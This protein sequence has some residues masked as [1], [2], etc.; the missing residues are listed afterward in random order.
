MALLRQAWLG[1]LFL[2]VPVIF[3]SSDRILVLSPAGEPIEIV[4]PSDLSTETS[5]QF[6]S[7]VVKVLQSTD[8]LFYYLLGRIGGQ[9]VTVVDADSLEVSK[10]IPLPTGPFDGVVTPDGKYLLVAAAE[11]SVI[12]LETNELETTVDVGNNARRVLVDSSSSMAF[13]I[14]GPAYERRITA[15]SL[16]TMGA[17]GVT[18]SE[19]RLSDMTFADGGV[20]LVVTTL[21]D[22]IVYSTETLEEINRFDLNDTLRDPVLDLVSGTD[23]VLV[24]GQNLTSQ[25]T[26]LLVDFKTGESQLVGLSGANIFETIH[27]FDSTRA[28]GILHTTDD[29]VQLDLTAVGRVTVESLGLQIQ[30]ID[31]GFSPDRSDL[32]VVEGGTPSILKID[33]A[34]NEVVGSSELTVT[35]TGE[36]VL[37]VPSD[38]PPADIGVLSGNGQIILAGLPLTNPLTARVLDAL[39][40]PVPNVAV[41]FEDFAGAGV[42]FQSS[43]STQ[44][45]AFGDAT[46]SV[47]APPHD[48][49]Q[50]AGIRTIS[51]SAVAPNV[52]PAFFSIDVA[53]TVGLLKVS[54]DHQIVSVFSDFPKPIV[55]LATDENGDL[56]PP[57]TE[58]TVATDQATCQGSRMVDQSGFI[59]ATC[60]SFGIPSQAG[61][62]VEGSVTFRREDLGP[63]LGIARFEFTTALAAEYLQIDR[64]SGDEQTGP[65]GQPLFVPLV[66]KIA[67]TG[68]NNVAAEVTQESG[69]PVSFSPVSFFGPPFGL[70]S[71][72]AVAGPVEG[73]ATVKVEVPAPGFPSVTFMVNMTPIDAT[74]ITKF[75]DGQTGSLFTTLPLPLIVTVLG[76][77]GQPILFPDVTWEVVSGLA[78]IETLRTSTGSRATV[79]FG[80][81]PGEILIRASIGALSAIFSTMIEPPEPDQL[82]ILSG[83]GQSLEAGVPS[84][85]L[86]V[87]FREE[88]RLAAG[89]VVTVTGP[90]SL[91]FRRAGGEEPANPLVVSADI[92]GVAQV[93]VELID[94]SSLASANQPSGQTTSSFDVLVSSGS[95]AETIS[96]GVIGRTP[97]FSASSITNAA[98]FQAVGLVPGGLV[99][100]FGNGFMQGITQVVEPGGVT[101]FAG[102]TV[103]IDGEKAPLLTLAPGALEQVNVQVPFEL[104]P[105]QLV[106][107]M[108]DNNGTMTTV[109]NVAVFP[110]QPGIFALPIGDD[111]TGGAVLHADDFS[112]VTIAN[113]AEIG[114]VL[115]VYYTG[116]GGLVDPGVPTG[117]LG[118][119]DPPAVITAQ[120]IL[121]V[122]GVEAELLFTGYAP[123][124]LGLYQTNFIVPEGIGCGTVSLALELSAITGPNSAL[125]IN[126]P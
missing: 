126:C 100:I 81:L 105:G 116:G 119:V 13:V 40:Q 117:V 74:Q 91:L 68:I 61:V 104:T 123:S 121:R 109:D 5:L 10:V 79:S 125:P 95:V 21:T 78:T 28:Y 98:T 77:G 115:A 62:A 59:T 120:S 89:A 93:V 113:P 2:V 67:S 111:Q 26:T 32:F 51:I 57:G 71:I 72:S 23:K 6:T 41:L 97:E 107:V 63:E 69:P 65:V 101:S 112:F 70:E 3:A 49:Q 55:V 27:V 122:D 80:G 60:V 56:L 16:T 42:Q 24:Q 73:A 4:R 35:P 53:Q 75:N 14:G 22:V 20:L 39:G 36:A 108:I 84:E 50:E 92:Q 102:T 82:T 83:Q 106:S 12:D 31:I 33:T 48:A 58:V 52:P 96:F 88:G 37:F 90:P 94:I 25:N 85:P 103:W 87:V 66:F 47:V 76:A 19:V 17:V 8:G 1:L 38:L 54:G 9:A 114:E 15:V 64:I 44:T 7:S 86:T 11:L 29:L 124:F 46:V 34:V 118:P 99:S 45:N 30:A 18:A 110:T 43:Q